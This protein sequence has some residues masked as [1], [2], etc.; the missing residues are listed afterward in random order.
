MPAI[1]AVL[2]SIFDSKTSPFYTE[3]ADWARRSR[4]FRAFA[5]DHRAKI[6]AKL[7]NARDDEGLMDVRAELETAAVLLGDDRFTLD[8]EKYAA[9]KQRGPDFT[10]TFRTRTPFNVEVRRIRAG[11]DGRDGSPAHRLAAVF[12]DKARQMPSGSVN[13]LWLQVER[14]IADADM[15]SAAVRLRQLAESK[16]E[17]YFTRRG[18]DS[19]AAFLRQYRHLSGV[20]LYRSDAPGVWLNPLAHH[21]TPPELIRALQQL[22]RA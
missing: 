16:A 9:L 17:D 2:D 10:V 7:R 21:T 14:E 18:Y 20:V 11:D 8:Y 4:R 6:R 13:L 15:S 3:F 19:A 12:C 5:Y 1:D 22:G